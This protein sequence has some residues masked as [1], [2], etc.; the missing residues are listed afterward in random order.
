MTIYLSLHD[1]PKELFLTICQKFSLKK[2]LEFGLVSTYTLSVVKN[3]AWTHVMPYIGSKNENMDFYI[4]NYKFMN[5]AF[6]GTFVTNDVLKKF[7]MLNLSHITLDKCPRITK[8]C[9]QY[10][11]NCN[12]IAINYN[13]FLDDDDLIYFSNCKKVIIDCS[14]MLTYNGLKTLNKCQ[15]LSIFVSASGD[16]LN[17]KLLLNNVSSVRIKYFHFSG[18]NTQCLSNVK[19][20]DL[21]YS[22][23]TDKYIKHFTNCCDINLRC[24][25]N[26]NGTTLHLLKNLHTVNLDYCSTI[27]DGIVKQLGHLFRLSLCCCNLVT[28]NGIYF[29]KNV[30]EL[31]LSGCHLITNKSV[32]M[33]GK[34]RK[35]N[36]SSCKNITNES[37]KKL[38]KLQ[39]IC[40]DYCSAITNQPL[41][42]LKNCHLISVVGCYKITLKRANIVRDRSCAW[43]DELFR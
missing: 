2:L 5:Y 24:C 26:I 37:I 30:S 40:I 10:L 34:L 14:N 19:K 13:F 31:N 15:E 4:K 23:I 25:L 11:A 27:T 3:T 21:Q 22:Q 9:L 28:D 17:Q 38:K 42:A 8:N 20:L 16:V 43:D 41:F 33:L 35:L 36:I 32:K 6:R 39:N 1:V 18:K 12:T 29:L 7:S